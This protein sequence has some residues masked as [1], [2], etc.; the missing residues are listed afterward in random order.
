MNIC[1]FV[2][3]LFPVKIKMYYMKNPEKKWCPCAARQKNFIYAPM[4]KP[5]IPVYAPISVRISEKFKPATSS[6]IVSPDSTISIP[7]APTV[8]RYTG[9]VPYNART[10]VVVSGRRER[11]DPDT[12]L[13][14]YGNAITPP[15][16]S[17]VS[18]AQYEAAVAAFYDALNTTAPADTYDY[19]APVV[20]KKQ[21]PIEATA[22][23]SLPA[24]YAEN[25][26]PLQVNRYGTVSKWR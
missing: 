13:T 24:E 3:N 18:S 10:A 11:F 26:T 21:I 23:A 12:L 7:A 25:F 6:Q 20:I 4:D 2:E 5:K 19:D 17:N 8:E 16:V 15:T 14:D 9:F 22:Y 1:K